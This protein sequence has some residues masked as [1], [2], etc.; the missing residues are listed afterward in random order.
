MGS[1]S[2]PMTAA[3][4]LKSSCIASVVAKTDAAIVTS[5]SGLIPLAFMLLKYLEMN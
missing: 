5:L 3:A 4:S 1:K 2:T